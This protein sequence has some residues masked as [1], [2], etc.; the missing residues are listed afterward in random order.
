MMTTDFKAADISDF[1]RGEWDNHRFWARLGEKPDVRGLRVLEIGS[2][3]GS[4]CVDLAR[5]GAARVVGLDLKQN[6]V[7]FS[8]PFVHQ[9]YPELE[10]R[11]TFEATELAN[12]PAERSD[13]VVSKDSFE[14][15]LDLDQMLFEMRRRLQPGAKS[16]SASGRSTPVPTAITI[17]AGRRSGGMAPPASWRRAFPGGTSFSNNPSSAS[18]ARRGASRCVPCTSWV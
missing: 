7:D 1:R 9:Y 17:A 18:P 6:L 14:H 16:T 11:L 4:L 10:D 2:G 8:R 5:A 15:I 3:W 12:Y 13:I